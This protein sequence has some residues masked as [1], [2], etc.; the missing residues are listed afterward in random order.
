MVFSWYMSLVVSTPSMPMILLPCLYSINSNCKFWKKIITIQLQRKT[1]TWNQ[2]NTYNQLTTNMEKK[3]SKTILLPGFLVWEAGWLSR[4]YPGLRWPCSWCF[5]PCWRTWGCS[6]S[7]WSHGRKERRRR[8]SRSGCCRRESL[9]ATWNQFHMKIVILVLKKIQLITI[10][11]IFQI[12][13][14]RIL[15]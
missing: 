7:P 3:R 5:W 9:E 14:Y 2:D 6:G 12:W 13:S 8:S 15:V 11:R 10:V 4:S 1:L